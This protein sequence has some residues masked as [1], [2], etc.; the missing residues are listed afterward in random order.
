MIENRNRY[1]ELSGDY[2]RVARAIE[3]LER[4]SARQ[5]SLKEV[6]RLVHL[7]EFHFQRLFKRWAGITPKRFRQFLTIE[8]AK[9]MLEESRSLLDVSYEAG[10]S[11]TSRLHDLFVSIEAITPGEF[12]E[13]GRGVTISYGIHPTPFGDCLL[14]VTDRGVC[15]LKFLNGGGE[16]KEIRQLKKEWPAARV[17]E[18]PRT[19]GQYV[20]KIFERKN[21]S[22]VPVMLQGTNFQVKVWEALLKIPK[23]AIVSYEDVASVL[24][25]PSATRVVASAIARNPVVFLIPCHRVIRKVVRRTPSGEWFGEYQ[26]GATRKKAILVWESAVRIPKF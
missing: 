5:P 2:H 4:N 26:G 13:K 16:H 20:E 25:T 6:A 12:K 15:R 19:T 17:V 9:K 21:R 14:G 10:L 24:G 8:H 18:S 23:G 1:S 3:F 11:S 7:S 22:P